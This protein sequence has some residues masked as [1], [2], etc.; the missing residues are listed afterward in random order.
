MSILFLSICAGNTED[1]LL[2]YH[3]IIYI[4]IKMTR[5]HFQ[6]LLFC[7]WKLNVLISFDANIAIID[8]F[9]I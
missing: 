2:V 8:N 3:M 9:R 5:T 1:N 4:S 7:E 6:I